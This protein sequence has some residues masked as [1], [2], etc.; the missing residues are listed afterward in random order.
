MNLFARDM[1]LLSP[2]HTARPPA[3][4]GLLPSVTLWP[5]IFAI[6]VPLVLG[7]VFLPWFIGRLARSGMGQRIR[8]E[9]PRDHLAKAG[10]PTAGGL[11]VIA[12]VLGTVVL[13]DRSSL[14]LPAIGAMLLGGTLGLV[15]DVVT[16]RGRTRGLLAR[17]KILIQLIFGLILGYW[18]LKLGQDRQLLPWGT[19]KMGGLLLPAAALALVASSNAFN[20]TDGSDGLAPGVMIVVALGIALIA[21]HL[22]HHHDV[23]IVRLTLATAGALLAF[24]YYNLPPARV[25]LGGVGAEGIGMLLAA[26]A[27]STGL[28]WYLP[29]LALIP[30]IETAS[31]IA[32][33]YFFKR[34]G[35]RIFRM[36]PIHHHFQ[37]GGWGEWRVALSAWGISA[38]SGSLSL[39][40]TRQAT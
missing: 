8:D 35:R 6:G 24:L 14:V 25:I 26:S 1:L 18:F 15:D 16:V 34:D 17:Q 37:L 40:L 28:L 9:G 7:F 5:P 32:Q 27:I 29:L 23:A 21:R 19:W 12:L 22:N 39:L 13:M 30:L 3:Q 36:A 2:T 31:V 10:T 4:H 33:V 38:A 11:F 20:L